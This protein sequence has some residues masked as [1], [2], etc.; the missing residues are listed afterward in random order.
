MFTVLD[1]GDFPRTGRRKGLSGT[2]LASLV[3]SKYEGSHSEQTTRSRRTKKFRRQS[4]RQTGY[5][6]EAKDLATMRDSYAYLFP[7]TVRLHDRDTGAAVSIEL[8][9]IATQSENTKDEGKT[10]N[11]ETKSD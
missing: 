8:C 6:S 2:T 3:I 9:R 11:K 7:K 5:L 10:H 1:Q 4:C